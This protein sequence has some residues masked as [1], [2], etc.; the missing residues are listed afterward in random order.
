MSNAWANFWNATF[1]ITGVAV[2]ATAILILVIIPSSVEIPLPDQN[3]TAYCTILP[4]K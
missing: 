3:M 4:N 2:G 1:F